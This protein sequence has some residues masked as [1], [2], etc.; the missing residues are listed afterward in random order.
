M[1]AIRA[2]NKS[3]SAD[4]LAVE[5]AEVEMPKMKDGECLV[6]IH[7]SGVNPSDV[8]GLLGKMPNLVWPRIPGRDYS[9]VVVDGPAVHVG[10][11]VWGT[12]GDLGMAR[13]G[14]HAQYMIA[15]AAGVR[16]KPENL[17]MAQAGSLGVA[18]T[19]AWLGLVPGARI[20]AGET[21]AVLGANGRVGEASVQ[22]AAGLGARVIAVERARDAYLGHACAPVDLVDLRT[23]PDLQ[24]AIAERTQGRGADVIMNTV[25]D[26]YFEAACNALAK[27]GR[28]III[29]TLTEDCTI[30]L[31][32]FYRGNHRMIGVSNMDHDHI[33]SGRLLE[34]MKD[35][36]ERGDYKSA[37]IDAENVFGL[38]R[39]VEAYRLVLD[40]ASRGRAVIDPRA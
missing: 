20:A 34:E 40:G 3:A 2:A 27:Q 18:W 21:V 16:A 22:I 32:T 24:H 28:Q 5:L 4:A 7:A 37:P 38:A 17:T 23:E 6:E 25:G 11:Q 15:D 10:A 39:A 9:G 29:T 30:N 26:P 13:D 36:F 1:K 8:K 33:V 14:A 19:C 35:G 12:G 31:R